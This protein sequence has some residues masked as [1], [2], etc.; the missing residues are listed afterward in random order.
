MVGA[1]RRTGVGVG[2]TVAED[3]EGVE[4]WLWLVVVVVV[5]GLLIGLIGDRMTSLS[6]PLTSSISCCCCCCCVGLLVVVVNVVGLDNGYKL[7]LLS[8]R[9][10]AWVSALFSEHW[11]L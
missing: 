5:V 11:L 4:T 3:S 7:P 1:E 9:D 10:K 2:E 8:L 6:D